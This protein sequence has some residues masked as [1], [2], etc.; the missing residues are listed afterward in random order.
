ML[1]ALLCL[2]AL[3]ACASA[4]CIPNGAMNVEVPAG[5][6]A[7]VQSPNFGN[8]DYPNN[9]FCQ[10]N[11]HSPNSAKLAIEINSIAFS[12]EGRGCG[13]DYVTFIQVNSDGKEVQLG[14]FCGETGPQRLVASSTLVK[15][16]FRS[17]SAI[18]KPGFNLSFSDPACDPGASL[19]PGSDSVCIRPDQYCDETEDCP[20]A[21]D[22]GPGCSGECGTTTI[23]PK[24][25][26]TARA[27]RS[28]VAARAMGAGNRIVGGVE[29]EPHSLPWQVAML[30]SSGSQLCG[31]SII[32]S[33]WVMTAAHCCKAYAPTTA[34]YRV[35]VGAHVW[36][37]TNEPYAKTYSLEKLFV[38]PSYQ[39]PKTYSNDFCL[40]KI[41]GIFDF[42]AHVG[43]ICLAD[44]DDCAAGTAAMVSGWGTTNPARMGDQIDNFDE[45]VKNIKD[46]EAGLLAKDDDPNY[47]QDARVST[48][49]Q[50][51][52]DVIPQAN[53]STAYPGSVSGDMICGA[54]PGKDSCQGDS[55]GPL[56]QKNAEGS[57]KLC[58]VV[59]WGRGCAQA[60]Y[61][62]V[63]A[64]V[65]TA[66]E[67]ILS[68]ILSN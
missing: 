14:K 15:F 44:D 55:G 56:V 57:W 6:K 35:R 43:A 49:R 23:P 18:T 41:N 20:D 36:S 7:Y 45:F 40:L 16:V 63:Y 3:V 12:L 21:S 4:Q 65:A 39:R 31:G 24:E 51:Y 67:W 68:T 48:L 25:D 33:Q 17:D 8:G 34:N 58:G 64:R 2:A 32:N 27:F 61:P 54:R 26:K 42:G 52:V 47:N 66:T 37:A 46:A 1:Q 5:G 9:A 11:V 28:L 59:S 10:W 30:T 29:A 62:G 50:V 19:C 60:R 13:Y 53:C 22:E 38:H